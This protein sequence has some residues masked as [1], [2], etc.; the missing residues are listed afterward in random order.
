MEEKLKITMQEMIK[1]DNNPNLSQE[2]LQLDLIQK[3]LK[4]NKELRPSTQQILHHPLFWTDDKSLSL[5]LDIRKKFDVLSAAFA[6]AIDDRKMD[7]QI[8]RADMA[9]LKRMK[10]KL[11]A[12]KSVV[13]GDWKV[14]L[15]KSL[16]EELRKGYK[17]YSVSDLLKVIRDK[18]N[19]F[20]IF[21]LDSQ[22]SSSKL[23]VGAHGGVQ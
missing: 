16:V 10:V 23:A 12:D 6:K 14:Q 7:Y 18:V 9:A 22:K 11:D 20:S 5:F 21:L 13:K 15:D 4:L 2:L 19:Y 3:M 17:K 1:V 8:V